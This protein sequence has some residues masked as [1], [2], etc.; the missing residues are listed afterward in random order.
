MQEQFRQDFLTRYNM[1]LLSEAMD[2]GSVYF[3]VQVTDYADTNMSTVAHYA[4]C[5]L[6]FLM[7]LIPVFLSGL[8]TGDLKRPI[9]CR[10]RGLGVGDGAFLFGKILLPFGFVLLIVAGILWGVTE[11]GQLKVTL[12]SVFAVAAST[13]PAWSFNSL[14][15]RSQRKAILGSSISFPVRFL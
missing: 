3:D 14:P 10:L 1:R 5:W 2:A 15:C 8:Y 4:L 11:I 6:T 9:L 13:L 7:M 12:Q